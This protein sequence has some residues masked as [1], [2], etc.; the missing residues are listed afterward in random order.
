MRRFSRRYLLFKNLLEKYLKKVLENFEAGTYKNAFHQD[1]HQNQNIFNTSKYSSRTFFKYLLTEFFQGP[2]QGGPQAQKNCPREHP[3]DF[4]LQGIVTAYFL[5]S[6]HRQFFLEPLT[7]L[8]QI[9]DIL[10]G[11]EDSLKNCV[12]RYFKNV[13]E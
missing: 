12:R 3:P 7:F 9:I 13:L 11:W 4:G 2:S 8:P 10:G 6:N 5:S 1:S